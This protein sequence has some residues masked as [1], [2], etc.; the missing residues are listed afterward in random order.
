[1]TKA[2]LLS[3]IRLLSAMESVMLTN[4]ERIPDYLHEQLCD[5]VEKLCA[6]VLK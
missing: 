6:E 5:I 3:I 4:K 2:D 1:M